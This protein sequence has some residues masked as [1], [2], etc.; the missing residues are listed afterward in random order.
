MK[1]TGLM[2]AIF[3][4]MGFESLCRGGLSPASIILG[5]CLGRLL[6]SSED[7]GPVTELRST[8]HGR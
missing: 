7:D 8:V 5:L 1:P 4:Y 6:S 2:V 3:L